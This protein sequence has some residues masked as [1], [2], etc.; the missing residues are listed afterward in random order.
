MN[1]DIYLDA[2]WYQPYGTLTGTIK[3]D[4]GSGKIPQNLTVALYWFTEGKGTETGETVDE[5]SIEHS[6]I[7]EQKF[8]FK[9][10]AGPY[11]FSGNLITLKW[12]VE[13]SG[14]KPDFAVKKEFIMSPDSNPIVLIK[15]KQPSNYFFQIE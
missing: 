5:I 11:S 10:P 1:Y 6:S 8:S 2:D 14:E 9:L 15:V 12:A 4:F 13:F 3:W 7:G